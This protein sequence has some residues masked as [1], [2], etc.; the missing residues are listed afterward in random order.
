MDRHPIVAQVVALLSAGA[1]LLAGCS[2]VTPVAPSGSPAAG[3]ERIARQAAEATT[4]S[5]LDPA[6]AC[7][8]QSWVLGNVYETL[9]RYNVPGAEPLIVPGLA[10]DWTVSE[11]GMTWT[12]HLQEGVKFHDGTDFTSEAVKFTVERNLELNQCSAY[13]YSAV[14]SIETPDPYTVVFHLSAPAPM[15]AVLASVFNAW[16]MSPSVKDKDGAWFNA[17]NEVGTGP[18]RIAQFEPGQRMVLEQNP[19]YWRGWEGDE[20]DQIVF[21][22]VGDMTAAEQ[23]LRAGQLDFVTSRALTPEQMAS[24]DAEEALD[25]V[26]TRGYGNWYI[27]LDQRRAPLDNLLVRQALA[28]SF[29]YDAVLAATN[30][31]KGTRA[32]GAVPAIVPGH[33]PESLPYN[34]D[35][36][37]AKALL[38]EAGYA[39]GFE[40]SIGFDPEERPMAELWQAELAKIGVK[41]NLEQ[42]D[43]MTRW[44]TA[45]VSDSPTAPAANT[46]F[47]G[48]D[49]IGPYTYLVPFNM[50]VLPDWN[51]SR[52][53]NPEY[54][55]LIDEANVLAVTDR[56][57]ANEKFITAQRM[58]R[59]DVAAIFI[60]DKPDLSI[61]A[62]D[63]TGYTP[64]PAYGFMIPWY[65]VRR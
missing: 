17:G 47:W 54:N 60:M 35:L 55:A 1:L 22:L 59:D 16:I 2:P 3:G 39:D 36:E 26:A 11:D 63:L 27:Y 53:D 25:L 7:V 44:E 42:A 65:D 46:I 15:D 20:F 61:V 30:L 64:N 4:F 37:K 12:F 52:Y 56:E 57:A 14:E 21:E 45:M 33:D 31:G 8:T 40:F 18:Y 48:P 6:S 50:E 13:I 41:L 51:F 58:L 29:P 19:D 5:D 32:H 24:L 38:A 10:T 49:V 28:Y 62:S 23:M 9:T 43:F 34:F